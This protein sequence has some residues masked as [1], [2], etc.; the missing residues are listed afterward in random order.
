MTG[1]LCNDVDTF[2]TSEISLGI[3]RSYCKAAM[4][5]VR[6]AEKY[7][8]KASVSD[9]WKALFQFENIYGAKQTSTLMLVGEVNA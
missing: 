7:Q 5:K 4:R 9:I 1:A 3:G 6:F 2:P 8:S